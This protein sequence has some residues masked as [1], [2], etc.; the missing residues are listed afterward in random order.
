MGHQDWT[1]G[2]DPAGP[3]RG[4]LGRG[5]VRRHP[6]VSDWQPGRYGAGLGD[7]HRTPGATFP[8]HRGPVRVVALFADRRVPAR[9][10]PDGNVAPWDP[11][12]RQPMADLEG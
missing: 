7:A 11:A 9:R 8:G 10:G 1:A 12:N 2:Y 4:D 6:A 5:A 3:H